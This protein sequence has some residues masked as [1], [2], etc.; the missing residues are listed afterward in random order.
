[1]RGIDD[2]DR[3]FT[4]EQYLF[5]IC[6]N[7]TI[8]FLRRRKAR[9]LQLGEDEDGPQPIEHLAR[10][11]ETP[12]AIVRGRELGERALDL[13]AEI[14]REWVEETWKEEEFLRL[15]VVEALFSGQWR[16]RDVWKRFDLRDETAVAGI[17]FRALKR[18]R[19]L[20]AVKESGNDLLQYLAAAEE[21]DE[22]LF[23]LDLKTLW[24]DKRVS[25]PARHWIARLV[26]GTLDEKPKLFVQFHLDE[27]KCPW[28]LANRD[29]LAG[30]GKEA[31][32]E[33]LIERLRES[34]RQFLRSRRERS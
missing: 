24:R 20:A 3:Q 18:L 31:E 25:C 19:Q 11:T 28:C 34:T 17:K 7:R 14:L 21:G 2:F 27:M 33:L 10:E 23:D 30:E 6:K 29:D 5:G 16:N 22:R 1:V 8:D 12:S 15:C 9:V 13:Y 32:L 4:F 26:A